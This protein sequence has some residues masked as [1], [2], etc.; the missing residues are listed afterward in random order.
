MKSFH[1]YGASKILQECTYNISRDCNAYSFFDTEFHNLPH[2]LDGSIMLPFDLEEHNRK[3]RAQQIR[4]FL[5][6]HFAKNGE[7]VGIPMGSDEYAY[8]TSEYHNLSE[9]YHHNIIVPVEEISSK[10]K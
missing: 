6:E 1:L 7:A 10:R 9:D 2:D 4:E 8:F 3:N 5:K